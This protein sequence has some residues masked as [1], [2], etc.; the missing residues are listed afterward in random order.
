MCEVLDIRDINEQ[1]K[2]LTDSQRVKFTKEIKGLKIEITHCGA[3]KRKYRVC[4]VTRKPAQMQ[5]Y[6]YIEIIILSKCETQK[7]SLLI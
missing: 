5:S 2:P 3:M 6:V 1:R 7:R 4:N